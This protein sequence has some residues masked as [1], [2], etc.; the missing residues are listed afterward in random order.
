VVH[1]LIYASLQILV[2]ITGHIRF[3]T[4]GKITI[5]QLGISFHYLLVTKQFVNINAL[6]PFYSVKLNN[7]TEC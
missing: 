5:Q 7:V 4:A 6:L 3:T 1:H 2:C